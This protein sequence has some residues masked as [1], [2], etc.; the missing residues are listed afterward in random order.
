MI[1]R[2]T[3]KLDELYVSEPIWGEIED[4]EGINP[5]GEWEPVTFNKNGELELRI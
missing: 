4:R 2:N 3:L 5:A 1:I